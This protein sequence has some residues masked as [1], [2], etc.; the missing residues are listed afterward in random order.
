M[1]TTDLFKKIKKALNN[2]LN[3][4]TDIPLICWPNAEDPAG[5]NNSVIHLRPHILWSTS[6]PLE[7]G[8]VD[9][10]SGIFQINI[11]TDLDKTEALLVKWQ[12]IIVQNFYLSSGFLTQDDIV[13]MIQP[14]NISEGTRSDK[15]WFGFVEIPFI[16]QV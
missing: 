3:S 16:V 6:T 15:Y 7:I 8:S 9:E 1:A 12:D 4:I 2:R 10:Y 13:L 5:L 14:G 11:Y